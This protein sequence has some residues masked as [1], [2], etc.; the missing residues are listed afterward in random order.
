MCIR[1]RRTW[2]DAYTASRDGRYVV[3]ADGPDLRAYDRTTDTAWVAAQRVGGVDS[4]CLSPDG[5]WLAVRAID[6]TSATSTFWV[7]TLH[8]VPFAPGFTSD[9]DSK[10]YSQRDSLVEIGGR[11][12]WV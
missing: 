4:P 5:R 7:R 1:D 8:I 9:V 10:A 11:M 3:W 6:Q 2:V 12:D